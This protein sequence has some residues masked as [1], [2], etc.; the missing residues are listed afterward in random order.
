MIVMEINENYLL[1]ADSQVNQ[2]LLLLIQ[3]QVKFLNLRCRFLD[4]VLDSLCRQIDSACLE[5]INA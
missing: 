1:T 2:I 3:N 4:I 5:N